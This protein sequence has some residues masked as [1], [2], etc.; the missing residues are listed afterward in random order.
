MGVQP[1]TEKTAMGARRSPTQV[2]IACPAGRSPAVVQIPRP[3]SPVTRE[4]KK[5]N[6]H[7]KKNKVGSDGKRTQNKK[8][9]III[10]GGCG[11]KENEV[12]T[13]R[14]SASETTKIVGCD[15]AKN[16]NRK[17]LAVKEEN[18]SRKKKFNKTSVLVV[19]T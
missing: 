9:R 19:T 12:A 7:L 8:S 18:K 5:K 4:E 1:P 2:L 10:N 3:R 11:Y 13:R 6:H 14:E 16:Q 17:K 15:S